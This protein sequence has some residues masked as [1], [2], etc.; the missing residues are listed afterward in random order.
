[1]AIETKICKKYLLTDAKTVD[2]LTPVYDEIN[3]WIQNRDDTKESGGYILG[4]R[5]EDTGNYTLEMVTHPYCSDIRSRCF[6]GIRDS[7]HIEI[8][9]SERKCKRYYMG[10]WHTHPEDSPIPSS[11][12]WD[13]WKASVSDGDKASEYVFFIIAGRLEVKIWAGS[14]INKQ[15]YELRECDNRD[16]LYW[17][18]EVIQ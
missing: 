13:D 16:G 17:V 3:N 10:V 12:D 9:E 18:N 7:K 6:F 15:I 8:L 5:H 2:V 14:V 4:Y 11:I 1:M